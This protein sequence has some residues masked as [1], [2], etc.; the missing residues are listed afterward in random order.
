MLIVATEHAMH[1][2][3]PMHACLGVPWPAPI[4]GLAWSPVDQV[5]EHT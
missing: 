1:V 5:R 4:L 2:K 3:V